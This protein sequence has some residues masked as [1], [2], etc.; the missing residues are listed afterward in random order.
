M[1]ITKQKI[2]EFIQEE[3]WEYRESGDQFMILSGCP[4]CN[5]KGKTH[6]YI[7][8]STGQYYCHKCGGSGSFF[9][10]QKEMGKSPKKDRPYIDKTTLKK[11][12]IAPQADLDI[13]EDAVNI[14]HEALLKE[15]R[16]MKWLTSV[17]GLKEDTIKF[18]KLGWDGNRITIPVFYHSKL[19]TMRYRKDPYDTNPKNPKY[20]SHPGSD[21][22]LFNADCLDNKTKGTTIV[23]GEFD[24]MTYWQEVNKEVVTSTGGCMTFKDEWVDMFLGISRINICF[25]NDEAGRK[26]AENAAKKLG[27]FRC[28]DI[29]L[30]KK[31]TEKKKDLND[32]F[33][34]DNKSLTDW[35]KVY[36][37]AN[38][39][40]ELSDEKITPIYDIVDISRENM[41]KGKRIRGVITG[42]DELDYCMEGMLPGD[43]IILSGQTGVGKTLTAQSFAMNMLNQGK[44]VMFFSLEMLPSEL[45][46]RFIMINTQVPSF[47]YAGFGRQSQLTH[48][49]EKRV[50]S[51]VSKLRNLPLYFYTGQ[52]KLDFK[53]LDDVST[54]AVRKYNAQIIF[55]DHLH[56]FAR[57][58]AQT[59]S[60]DI[61]DLVRDIKMLA[62][63]L[64][65][66][67]VLISHLRKIGDYKTEP[68]IDDLRDTSFSGQ[69][70]DIVLLLQ[71]DKLNDDK[72]ERLKMNVIIA[73][74][75]HGKEEKIPFMFI[76][77]NMR[78]I[79]AST[80]DTQHTPIIA[81]PVEKDPVKTDEIRQKML[82]NKDVQ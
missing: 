17:R 7:S 58:N 82:L 34:A 61:G 12:T 27:W 71:R 53:L 74:N 46:Q 19:V 68:S 32:F 81:Q 69:D 47:H 37:D 20:M 21:T 36:K 29:L 63:R 51:T 76:K 43:L 41:I 31:D 23:E 72:D 10:L 16:I 80:L 11:A 73:K 33:F 26:G 64:N 56:Y 38:K 75:R 55:I 60:T 3:Y 48:T 9:A 65:I 30:P 66:P 52:D 70:A 25:D 2:E 54:R 28:W 59:R 45:V 40:P 24:L 39:F 13:T 44:E 42:H 35:F 57:G 5:D 77:D 22:V 14:Y 79:E 8:Q 50:D 18:F 49:E 62:R 67:I 4:I 78:L 15:D 1:E 6:F